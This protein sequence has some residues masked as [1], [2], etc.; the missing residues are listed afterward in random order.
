[1]RSAPGASNPLEAERRGTWQISVRK[2][3]S[4]VHDA[5]FGPR[6]YAFVRISDPPQ[7]RRATETF[8]RVSPCLGASVVDWNSANS[9]YS[10]NFP[11]VTFS[12][13]CAELLLC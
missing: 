9:C 10:R 6:F 12:L 5:S 4:E 1:M 2:Q 8:I 3:K 11:S 7:R 13:L